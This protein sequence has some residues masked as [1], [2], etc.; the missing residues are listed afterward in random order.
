MSIHADFQVGKT[1]SRQWAGVLGYRPE[2][3]TLESRFG[4]M[5]AVMSLRSEIDFD[6]SNLGSLLFDELQQSYFD[7]DAKLGSLEQIEKA[8]YKVRQRIDTILSREEELV[9]SGINMELSVAVI[10]KKTLFLA[11]VGEARIFI[12]RNGE[13]ADVSQS[14]INPEND[15]FVRI[16]SMYLEEMDRLMLITDLAEIEVGEEKTADLLEN[17]NMQDMQLRNGAILLVGYKLAEDTLA[18]IKQ[19]EA[20]VDFSD[21]Q[22]TK[23]DE[24]IEL[25]DQNY[26]DDDEL[27]IDEEI[28]DIYEEESTSITRRIS[29]ALSTSASKISTKLRSLQSKSTTNY[30]RKPE[31]ENGIIDEESNVDDNSNRFT[32]LRSSGTKLY[33]K[34]LNNLKVLRRNINARVQNNKSPMYL[35]SGN[36]KGNNW[37][38]LWVIGLVVL[39]V[40]FLGVRKLV[41][42]RD[43]ANRLLAL[44]NNVS[45][46]EQRMSS[47]RTEVSGA[48]IGSTDGVKKDQVAD[49]LMALKNDVETT[50][51]DESEILSKE[52][53]LKDKLGKLITETTRSKDQVLNIRSF[54]EP[55]IVSDLAIN[56][57]GVSASDIAYANG[58]IY[59][60]DTAKGGIIRMS[61]QINSSTGIFATGFT[62]PYLIEVDEDGDLVVIDNNPDSVISTVDIDTAS[63][64]RHPGVSMAKMGT[65][66]AIDIW[67]NAALYTINPQKQAL[68]KQ[69]NVAGNYQLP[70]DASPWRSDSDFGQAI[71]LTID[72]WVYVI[73][74]GKGLMRYLAGEP[75]TYTYSGL[76]KSIENELKQA[77]AVELS[78][79]HLY[80]ADPVR[81][82]IVVFSKRTDDAEFF[83]YQEQIVYS[84]DGDVFKNIKDIVVNQ[85]AKQL[86]VL[87]GNKVIRVDLL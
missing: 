39:I 23:V 30:K 47:L 35:R 45:T 58:N 28:P 21:N 16:G 29:D 11:I 43:Y 42:D 82:R 38:I 80:L 85:T 69:D 20:K 76:P 31:F 46:L 59:V 40:L 66:S 53:D 68:L 25:V 4:E 56:N 7:E 22:E 73:V 75:T 57:E 67:S 54:T 51:K 87:D 74:N 70:N 63:V 79:T 32:Q 24:N 33:E 18:L 41:Q 61:T 48:T 13:T 83:D 5:F 26:F 65:L 10:R 8:M 2:E 71:D 44:E 81:Q 9:E 72:Y 1:S 77:K 55:Q 62:S 3:E 49:K 60:V 78:D 50:I 36:A 12:H 37:R 86:F 14:L 84:G 52:A 19:K 64:Y 34:L 6:L 17:L 15:D 27:D